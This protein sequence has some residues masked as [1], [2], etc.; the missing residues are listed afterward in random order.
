MKIRVCEKFGSFFC[1]WT[2]FLKFSL[3]IRTCYTNKGTHIYQIAIFTYQ[4]KKKKKDKQT[5]VHTEECGSLLWPLLDCTL[6]QWVL[7][8]IELISI[9]RPMISFFM[10]LRCDLHFLYHPFMNYSIF[11]FQIWYTEAHQ[12]SI[13]MAALKLLPFSWEMPHFTSSSYL[14]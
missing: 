8:L 4:K 12:A 1:L 10:H 9:V 14:C 5:R 2:L 11:W 3:I 6:W 13:Q 7:Q